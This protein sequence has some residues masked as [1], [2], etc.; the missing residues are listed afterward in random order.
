MSAQSPNADWIFACLWRSALQTILLLREYLCQCSYLLCFL[1]SLF[2]EAKGNEKHLISSKRACEWLTL[3]PGIG[4]LHS[5]PRFPTRK[6][7]RQQQQQQQPRDW[8]PTSSTG[9]G[10]ERIK[11]N[12][13]VSEESS[14][15]LAPFILC[16]L[17]CPFLGGDEFS[18]FLLS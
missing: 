18:W 17:Y 14:L 7:W 11:S 8:R 9:G 15:E 13:C 16:W 6:G 10:E 2:P 1:F 5:N 12:P 3:V 4:P